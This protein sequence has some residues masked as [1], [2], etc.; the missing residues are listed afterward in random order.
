MRRAI[1]YRKT[2]PQI[3]HTDG[4]GEFDAK[5]MRKIYKE[6]KIQHSFSRPGVPQDNPFI[7][8]FFN[9]FLNKFLYAGEYF[10]SLVKKNSNANLGSL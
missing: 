8:S 6:Y 7:E 4:G 1:A 2:S 5:N 3:L 10:R 9:L